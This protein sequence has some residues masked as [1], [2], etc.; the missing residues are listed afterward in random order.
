MKIKPAQIFLGVGIL[1]VIGLLAIA[2]GWL[3]R[4]WLAAPATISPTTPATAPAA[5]LEPQTATPMPSPTPT[6]TPPGAELADP[7]T[8]STPRPTSTTLPSPTPTPAPE[9]ETVRLG[10]GVLQVCRRHCPGIAGA[11][12]QECKQEV[13]R[14][15]SLW[16]SNPNLY[17][18]QRLLMP[19]C[20]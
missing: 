20:P 5:G 2:G 13:I 3:A 16:G 18:G 11:E 1:F 8:T 15:N 9:Y 10:E 12:L 7:K 19:S 14:L 6:E 4:Q 17:A